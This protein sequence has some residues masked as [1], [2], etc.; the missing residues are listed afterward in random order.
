MTR[1]EIKTNCRILTLCPQFNKKCEANDRLYVEGYVAKMNA[2]NRLYSLY[3]ND[4]PI[5]TFKAN[6]DR[7]VLSGWKWL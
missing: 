5:A 3:H 4:K 2:S 1:S 7:N 6:K